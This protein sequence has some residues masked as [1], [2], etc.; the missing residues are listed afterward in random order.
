MINLNIQCG[1]PSVDLRSGRAGLPLSLSLAKEEAS[2]ATDK[3]AL[4]VKQG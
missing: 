1:R 2:S 4:A 3:S